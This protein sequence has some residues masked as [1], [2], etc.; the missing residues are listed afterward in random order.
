MFV[1]I[2][3]YT[4]KCP[5]G[6]GCRIHQLHLCRRVR[7]PLPNEYP[8]YDTK[9]S[10]SEVPVMLELW[11]KQSTPSLPLLPGPLCFGVVASDRALSMGQIELNC[12]LTLN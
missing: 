4:F 6:W 7:H 2:S 10:D 1:N 12:I 3:C 11:R 8:E 9:Q 5:V